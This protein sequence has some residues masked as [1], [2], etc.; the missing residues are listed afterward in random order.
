MEMPI[1]VIGDGMDKQK[2]NP[3]MNYHPTVGRTMVHT[4]D[5]GEMAFKRLNIR[6]LLCRAED[7][8]Y[9]RKTLQ[10]LSK[11]LN[12]EIKVAINTFESFEPHLKEQDKLTACNA[13]GQMQRQRVLEK[14]TG[15][16]FP[17][18]PAWG[19]VKGRE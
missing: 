6:A 19:P 8:D 18:Y 10:S 7:E 13:E 17:D 14:L 16:A 12:R 2:T 9:V 4:P 1:V 5:E 3:M 11:T 15:F